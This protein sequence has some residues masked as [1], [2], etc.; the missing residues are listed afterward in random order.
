VASD[1]L[2]DHSSQRL[3]IAAAR[4]LAQVGEADLERMLIGERRY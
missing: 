3:P 1:K 4:S 2:V